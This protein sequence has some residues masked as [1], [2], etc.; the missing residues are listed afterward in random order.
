MSFLVLSVVVSCVVVGIGVVDV[1]IVL[2]LVVE[3]LVNDL[4]I[5]SINEGCFSVL[6]W[7]ALSILFGMSSIDNSLTIFPPFKT[8]SLVVLICELVERGVEVMAFK[9]VLYKLLSCGVLLT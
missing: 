4:M 7:D 6:C 5:C 1:V 9:I 8:G 2:S 3:F